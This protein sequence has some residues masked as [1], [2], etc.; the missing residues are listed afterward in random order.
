MTLSLVTAS[1]I[2]DAALARAR[3]LKLNPLGVAVL[4]AR[5][6][7]VAFK[8]EDG[9]GLLRADIARGKAAGCL[10]LNRGGRQ[11]T[12]LALERPHFSAALAAVSGGE[13][14]PVPGGVLVRDGAG[15]IV[16]AVGASGDSADND[17]ICA[18]AGIEAAG[19]VADTGA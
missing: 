4:D 19:L 17:E 5:G 2:V 15:R 6:V 11:L 1:T 13:F 8:G 14:M 10:G 16:G 12:A 18:V 9:G 3:A 7:L